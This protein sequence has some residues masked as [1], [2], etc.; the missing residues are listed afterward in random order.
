MDFKE[1]SRISTPELLLFDLNIKNNLWIIKARILYSL[2]FF[3]FFFFYKQFL[4]LEIIRLKDLILIFTLSQLGNILFYF[5]LRSLTKKRLDSP[6]I[7]E[8]SS[9]ANLQLDF[10]FVIISIILFVSG[11]INS[12]VIFFFILYIVISAFIVNKTKF[13]LNSILAMIFLFILLFIDTRFLELR[14]VFKLILLEIAIIF[15]F[16]VST[17]LSKGIKDNQYILEELLKKSRKLSITDNLSGLFNQRHFFDQLSLMLKKSQRYKTIFSLI[18][19]DIDNFKNYNDSN[20]HLKG[21]AAIEK[22]GKM[23]GEAFRDFDICARYGGDE[24]IVILPDTDKVG[25]FLAADRFR[26]IVENTEFP[27]ME[28]QPLKKITLSIG[29]SFFPENGDSIEKIIEKA[30]IALYRS[31]SEGRNRVTIFE[32]KGADTFPKNS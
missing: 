21:S 18:L 31:K 23:V 12:P 15:A 2:F 28:T 16:F 13:V 4:S 9:L 24:F 3:V 22:V 27:G 5:T 19:F 7:K 26:N 17:Y 20:G 30:D 10:D 11:G 14:N 25:A 8:L 1:D 6:P 29:I 32:K